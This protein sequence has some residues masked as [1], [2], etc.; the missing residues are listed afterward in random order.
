MTASDS[1]GEV[2]LQ[3][4]RAVPRVA[5]AGRDRGSTGWAIAHGFGRLRAN[6][7]DRVTVGAPL[8]LMEVEPV[9]P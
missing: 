4:G 6:V 3:S 2:R 7:A 8:V 1:V 9:V 5:A